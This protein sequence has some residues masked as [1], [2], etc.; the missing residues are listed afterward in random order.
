MTCED[1]EKQMMKEKCCACNCIIGENGENIN[2]VQL[3]RIA[4]WKYPVGGNILTGA[5]D[6]AVA[7]VCNV[8]IENNAPIN[9]AIRFDGKKIVRVPID[10][11]VLAKN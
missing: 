8:C 10:N 4:T 9:Y 1:F 2:I 7:V 5:R 3:P 11:L 6:R